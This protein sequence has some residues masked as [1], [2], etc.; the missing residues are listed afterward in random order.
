MEGFYL[1]IQCLPANSPPFSLGKKLWFILAA[2]NEEKAVKICCYK[3]Y[4]YVNFD[5]S[6]SVPSFYRESNRYFPYLK[7]VYD[8][9]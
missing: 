5:T 7:I 9:N 4:R 2:L 6:V 1:F 3:F 8:N